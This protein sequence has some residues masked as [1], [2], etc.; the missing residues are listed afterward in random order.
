M[1]AKIFLLLAGFSLFLFSC[2]SD[3]E[4]PEKTEDILQVMAPKRMDDGSI[5]YVDLIFTGDD[6]KSFNITTTEIIFFDSI[7]DKIYQELYTCRY[8]SFYFN[9]KPLFEEIRVIRPF[10]SDPGSPNLVLMLRIGLNLNKIYLYD[11][12]PESN[13]PAAQ[14]W[15]KELA[16]NREKRKPAWEIFINYLSK[17]GKIVDTDDDPVAPPH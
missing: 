3:S 10:S 1:K 14:E 12:W 11:R 13:N 16:E 9:E 17:E 6:I 7:F 8:V 15:N 5:S 2:S 4:E